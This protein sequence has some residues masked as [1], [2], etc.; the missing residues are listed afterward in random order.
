MS[1]NAQEWQTIRS[2]EACTNGSMVVGTFT[3]ACNFNTVSVVGS[4]GT[5]TWMSMLHFVGILRAIEHKGRNSH[6]LHYYRTSGLAQTHEGSVN[7]KACIYMKINTAT[8]NHAH[9]ISESSTHCPPNSM[10]IRV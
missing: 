8:P 6:L 1:K 5:H 2:N 10:K 9:Q 4:L 7:T 3:Q